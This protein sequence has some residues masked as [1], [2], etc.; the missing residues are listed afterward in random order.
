MNITKLREDTPG[1]GSI[2]HFNNAGASLPTQSVLDAV[3]NYLNEE[4]RVGGYMMKGNSND[5][6]QMFYKR[7]AQLIN[8]NPDEIAITSNAS[9]SFNHIL[10]SIPFEPGDEIITSE[11]EYGNSFVNYINL[12]NKKG[13]VLKVIPGLENGD[14]DLEAFEQAINPKTKLVAIAHIPTSSGAVLDIEAIGRITKKH[15]ILYLVDACQS[16]GQLPFDVEKVACDF[17]S[18]TSRK[19]QRGPRGLG[20]LY[21]R[22]SALAQLEPR[23]LDTNTAHWKPN[24]EVLL[25]RSIMMFEHWEK[26]YGL[27]LGYSEALRYLLELGVE[28]T[29]KRI[30]YLA[31]YTRKRLAEVPD[32]NV[33]D[34]GSK[35]CGIVTFN[36]KEIHATEVKA[37]LLK[38]NINV[39]VSL[40]FSSLTDM[41]RRGVDAAVRASVHYYNTEEE[42]NKMV[43][44]LS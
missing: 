15:G 41:Q 1:C 32:V 13:V 36:K 10:Y 38:S 42:I 11:I 35:K 29:W 2:M 24:Q 4:A 40:P 22:K 37:R 18:T 28:N 43:D 17:A 34:P 6:I 19:Y 5:Q 7:A 23:I 9:E 39:S 20:F 8:A 27:V 21:V 31:D 25:E 26:N 30:Q 16:I 33:L 14:F 12:K 3:I 44:Q